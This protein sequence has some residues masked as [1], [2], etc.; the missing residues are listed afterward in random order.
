MKPRTQ[1]KGAMMGCS[2]PHPHGQVW[3]LSEVPSYPATEL[4]SLVHFASSDPLA[5][6]APRGPHNRPCL[7][8]EYA[9]F[10]AGLKDNEDRRIVCQNE[11]WIAVVPWWAVWPFETLCKSLLCSPCKSVDSSSLPSTPL[12]TSHPVACPPQHI[13]NDLP[14]RNII[15]DYNQ[16]RQSLLHLLCILDGSTPKAN[17]RRS[18]RTRRK[19][20]RSSPHAFLSTFASKCDC[21]EILGW[22]RVLS[23]VMNC[24]LLNISSRRFELLS[25]PQ[26]D[27]TAEQAAARL[28][29][30]SDV[31][32]LTE[33]KHDNV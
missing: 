14:S 31:H 7:L 16:I 19:R 11:D 33:H 6:T 18:Y 22:V 26:R 8:C 24:N 29:A 10:E 27:I 4:A 20:R 15:S 23:F 17:P 32:Y 12:P 25:E 13:R 2:N 9:H 28:R 3:S 5:S 21:S 30:C 1:N